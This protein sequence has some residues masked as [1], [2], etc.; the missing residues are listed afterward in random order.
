MLRYCMD[1]RGTKSRRNNH[2][3]NYLNICYASLNA[4]AVRRGQEANFDGIR[5]ALLGTM[6][7]C[8]LLLLTSDPHRLARSP[9][10]RFFSLVHDLNFSFHSEEKLTYHNLLAQGRPFPRFSAALEDVLEVR[11]RGT[12][13]L[14]GI[15]L[16]FA[17][18]W[19]LEHSTKRRIPRHFRVVSA[20]ASS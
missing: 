8:P 9:E 16:S 3:R 6:T 10:N 7:I 1:P 19:P 12:T 17:A 13:V 15:E 20:S 18:T 5:T 11:Y 14:I 2:T 4:G